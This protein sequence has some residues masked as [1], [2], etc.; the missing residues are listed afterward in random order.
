MKQL[1]YTQYTYLNDEEREKLYQQYCKQNKLDSE[2][3]YSIH[4][5]FDTLDKREE[6]QDPAL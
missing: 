3:E 6:A 4:E 1:T 2:L 5:F